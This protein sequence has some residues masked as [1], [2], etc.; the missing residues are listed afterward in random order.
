MNQ[1]PKVLNKE[2]QTEKHW[3]PAPET[4]FDTAT[5]LTENKSQCT[6]KSLNKGQLKL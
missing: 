1:F 6:K 4:P 3:F 2:A 5:Y